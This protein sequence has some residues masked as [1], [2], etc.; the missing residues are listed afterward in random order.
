[1]QDGATSHTSKLV[2]NFLEETIPRRYVKK[3]QWPPKSP[4]ANPLD[5]YFWSR[6]KEKVYEGR[7]NKP[8]ESEAEMIRR[9]KSVWKECASNLPEIRKSM[10]QFTQRHQ[11]VNQC[12]GSSIKMHFA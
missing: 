10:K 2:Q 5:Y 6:V 1:M 8:F 11:A 12:N 4:D 3:D 7:L 9:I